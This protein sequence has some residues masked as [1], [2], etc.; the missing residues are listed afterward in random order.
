MKYI[1]SLQI[2]LKYIITAVTG[3]ILIF[4]AVI[5]FPDIRRTVKASLQ[6]LLFQEIRPVT[7]ENCEWERFGGKSDGGY[8]M[9]SNLMENAEILYSYGIGGGDGWACDV[10]KVTGLSVHQYDC[11][12]LR[13]PACPGLPAEKFIFHEE[14][15]E[16]EKQTIEG[17]I[18]DTIL[19]HLE[20]NGD[21]EKTLIIKMDVEGS[22]WETLMNTPDETLSRID[23]L[24]LEFHD[25]DKNLFQKLL[26]IRRLKNHFYI[27]NIH[28]NNH[29]CAYDISPFPAWAFQAQLV[30]K[31]IGKISEEDS[32]IFKPNPLNAPDT[33]A[34]PDC[35]TEW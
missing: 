34:V 24:S 4:L 28:F 5:Y 8:L 21:S 11:F 25:V 3:I 15:V 7:L 13:R 9:C 22:E 6:N 14:C 32:G 1:A 27:V 10:S 26:L 19:S 29:A 23:Q 16:G 20:Q 18:Y 12:D 35:Q 17:R 31:R 2:K 30:N 33:L